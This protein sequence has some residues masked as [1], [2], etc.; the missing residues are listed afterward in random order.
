[1]SVKPTNTVVVVMPL[2]KHPRFSPNTIHRLLFILKNMYQVGHSDR[3]NVI[4]LIIHRTGERQ[5]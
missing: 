2:P 5:T 4:S 3:P 1:M